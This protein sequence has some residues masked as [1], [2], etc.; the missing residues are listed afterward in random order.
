MIKTPDTKVL[1]ALA[2]LEHHERF[3]DVIHWLQESLT[4]TS[5]RCMA[6]RDEVET[7]RLQGAG[8]DLAE[9]LRCAANAR[10]TLNR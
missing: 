8:S 4:E 10:S 7:R 6:E 1:E 3:Q 2:V 5:E 9:I